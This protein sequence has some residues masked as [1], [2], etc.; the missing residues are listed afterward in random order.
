MASQRHFVVAGV[1]GVCH[2]GCG[3]SSVRWWSPWMVVVV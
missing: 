3:Q 1:V 2:G